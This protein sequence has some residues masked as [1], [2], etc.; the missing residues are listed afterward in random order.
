ME[1]RH[2]RGTEFTWS[3]ILQAAGCP[4]ETRWLRMQRLRTIQSGDEAEESVLGI[5][6]SV[7]GHGGIRNIGLQ[8]VKRR[9]VYDSYM[10]KCGVVYAGSHRSP[11]SVL[12]VRGGAGV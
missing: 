12:T 11:G 7:Q 2:C 8:R 10:R 9:S 6:A 3:T 4:P 1:V 5:E